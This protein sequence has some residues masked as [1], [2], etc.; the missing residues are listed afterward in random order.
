MNF[1]I[2]SQLPPRTLGHTAHTAIQ[3]H[4]RKAIKHEEAV[5]ADQDPECL[6]QMRVGL[7]RLR[8]AIQVFSRAIV[9]PKSIHDRQIQ[10]FAQALGSVRDLDVMAAELTPD[11]DLPKS[12]RKA[13]NKVLRKLQKIRSKHFKNMQKMLHSKKYA[14]FKEDLQDWLTLPKYEAI[15]QFPIQEV[16]SDFLLPLIS[17]TL[18][19]PGWLVGIEFETGRTILPPLTTQFIQEQLSE[20]DIQLHSLRKQVKR[21][22]YQTELFVEM[23]DQDYQEQIEEFKTIQDVLGEI[24]DSV[25]LHEFFDQQLK[26]SIEEICPQFSEH[27]NQKKWQAW[28]QWRSL[29]TKYLDS[30]FR[31]QL[32][33]LV[34][35]NT[36]ELTF[37]KSLVN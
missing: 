26:E 29:Q 34:M 27:L 14:A 5:L 32:R 16:L 10:K 37:T 23:F 12:E 21:V 8:T 9:L 7:R 36:S 15:A 28:Q 3:K 24:Q 6:H 1:Q 18:L 20:N 17:Q 35:P 4:F 22:R 33:S 25:V 30:Q 19:H 31:N 11:T 2:K 13:L